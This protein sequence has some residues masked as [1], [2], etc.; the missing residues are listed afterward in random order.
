MLHIVAWQ[1]IGL[2]RGPNCPARGTTGLP[3]G[4]EGNNVVDVLGVNKVVIT[5]CRN[6]AMVHKHVVVAKPSY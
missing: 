1:P 4:S 2:E 5:D 3:R 6:R